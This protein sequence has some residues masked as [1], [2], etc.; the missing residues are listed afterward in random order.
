MILVFESLLG[1]KCMP[2]CMKYFKM[3][4][5]EILPRVLIVNAGFY[6]VFKKK[7]SSEQ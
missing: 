7:S 3:S 6:Q 5:A 4:S 2:V 1:R